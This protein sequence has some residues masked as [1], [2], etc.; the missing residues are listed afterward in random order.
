MWWS[1]G[2][3]EDYF[4]YPL[5]R[6]ELRDFAHRSLANVR[7][8]VAPLY[9]GRT[10]MNFP[11]D[12]GCRLSARDGSVTIE[13]RSGYTQPTVEKCVILPVEMRLI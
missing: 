11:L 2:E 12:G 5:P 8:T 13:Q 9:E 3:S 10:I 7:L 6:I 4:P 1:R